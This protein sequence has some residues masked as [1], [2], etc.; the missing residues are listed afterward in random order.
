MFNISDN[1]STAWV[2]VKKHGLMLAVYLFA[3]G[4]VNGIISSICG[5]SYAAQQQLQHSLEKIS[6]RGGDIDYQE[7]LQQYANYSNNSVGTYISSIV[8]SILTIGVISVC[9]KLVKGEL[10]E[11]DFKGFNLP[12]KVYAKAFIVDMIVGI[13]VIIGFL[14]CIVPGMYLGA[15]LSM[16]QLYSIDN[17][18]ASIGDALKA[19]WNM[20]GNHVMSLIGLPIVWMFAAFVGFLCCCIGMYFAEAFMYLSYALAYVALYHNYLPENK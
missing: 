20:T 17:P 16:A 12:F 4:I 10:Q 13:I 8:G 14:L 5:P 1:L 19:S 7:I 3:I 2:M 18:E 6:S 11:V 9:I 15:R